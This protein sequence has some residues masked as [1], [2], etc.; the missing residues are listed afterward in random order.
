M[1]KNYNTN[2]KQTHSGN[3]GSVFSKCRGFAHSLLFLIIATLC[4]ILGVAEVNAQASITFPP[5]PNTS[6]NATN[7]TI[8][9]SQALTGFTVYTSLPGKATPSLSITNAKDLSDA[10]IPD[11]RYNISTPTGV[12]GFTDKAPYIYQSTFTANVPGVYTIY[13]SAY[14]GTSATGTKKITVLNNTD[15]SFT[16]GDQALKLGDVRGKD[17]SVLAPA[18][19]NSTGQKTYSV[20][21][22][23]NRSVTLTNNCLPEDLPAGT[24]TITVTVPST[25]THI[26]ASKTCKIIVVSS[27]YMQVEDATV[28]IAKGEAYKVFNVASLVRD[29]YGK[30][31]ADYDQGRRE[32]E[33]TIQCI[34]RP[35]G[36]GSLTITGWDSRGEANVT[37]VKPGVYKFE[38]T[39]D[40][41][42]ELGIEYSGVVTITVYK[43]YDNIFSHP[44]AAEVKRVDRLELH[45][46]LG[47]STGNVDLDAE[48]KNTV[49]VE[50]ELLDDNYNEAVAKLY[51]GPTR[52]NGLYIENYDHY[53]FASK[54]LGTYR[55]RVSVETPDAYS[56][57]YV[58]FDPYT[59]DFTVNVTGDFVVHDGAN[60]A[61]G[62]EYDLD[63]YMP[64]SKKVIVAAGGITYTCSSSVP[65][66]TGNKF[67]CSQLGTYTITAHVPATAYNTERNVSFKITVKPAH[68]HDEVITETYR[69]LKW[70]KN[71]VPAWD[72]T[73]HLNGSV[74][75][76]D[77][78][79][80]ID[81]DEAGNDL[82]TVTLVT[83][84]PIYAALENHIDFEGECYWGGDAYHYPLLYF[85]GVKQAYEIEGDI[86]IPETVSFNGIEYK[87]T[88]IG[89]SAF[90][91]RDNFVH[92]NVYTKSADCWGVNAKLLHVTFPNNLEKIDQYAFS[93][94]FNSQVPSGLTF[95]EGSKL[96]RIERAAF[97]YNYIS[98][99]LDF[100]NCKELESI[101][102]YAFSQYTWGFD[103]DHPASFKKADFSGC[104]KLS[105]F[106]AYAFIRNRNLKTLDV[107]NIALDATYAAGFGQYSF[108]DCSISELIFDNAFIGYFYQSCFEGNKLNGQT[109][110]FTKLKN[111]Y[112]LD[113]YPWSFRDT[114]VLNL[115]IPTTSTTFWQ[116][117]FDQSDAGVPALA[118]V[119]FTSTNA[120]ATVQMKKRV[121]I[122]LVF[123]DHGSANTSINIYA[124]LALIG[125]SQYGLLGLE[126]GDQKDVVD[127]FSDVNG[128]RVFPFLTSNTS[129]VRTMSYFRPLDYKNI[130]VFDNSHMYDAN[131]SESESHELGDF[132]RTPENI[133]Y[134]NIEMLT[135]YTATGYNVAAKQVTMTALG[136]AS[137][138]P[139][140]GGIY[141]KRKGTS[142]DRED[143]EILYMLT[144]P[145]YSSCGTYSGI[146][147]LKGGGKDAVDL[148]DAPH[149]TETSTQFISKGGTFYYCTG[150][151]LGAFKAYLDLP[152]KILT[153]ADQG[154]GSSNAK[155][156]SLSFIWEDAPADDATSV[157]AI[158]DFN[159]SSGDYYNMQGMKVKVPQA[160]VIYIHNGRKVIMK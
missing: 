80:S 25:S 137:G 9:L 107:S 39:K 76:A 123:G 45:D 49:N 26:N 128:P 75:G 57:E 33:W 21:N 50:Y 53:I 130:K 16:K 97:A 132:F 87:V 120:D 61:L 104:T 34:E 38:F 156:S 96:R 148:S 20:R 41:S 66:I 139:T 133:A 157:E 55:V 124:P 31:P 111:H 47:V 135:P 52:I 8:S 63:D 42:Y 89:N 29:V 7:Q 15:I 44:D 13:A 22:S 160:G 64:L 88:S 85:N 79:Y 99:D 4:S 59:H 113:F 92:L 27:E 74:A 126:G 106:G 119:F 65:V 6:I 32:Y 94:N 54:K 1:N 60:V 43:E 100:T 86:E 12:S 150:G 10:T 134:N 101:A 5:S 3:E 122:G 125:R 37:F 83:S 69:G 23:S 30:T 71:Y 116:Q 108:S 62:K 19:S 18:T 117:A 147:Y 70:N 118:N 51:N 95:K 158:T 72:F 73:Q 67:T 149:M 145:E 40:D 110:D 11:Y 159:A 90:L 36:V 68:I 81:Y 151:T 138:I 93:E 14:F 146:N 143:N 46:L 129:G 24:Y 77:V 136:A 105:T 28:T 140:K 152:E 153:A 142:T 98:E 141:Y 112:Y 102:D 56:G 131:K 103:P 17:I 127:E 35:E 114:G 91:R 155:V 121:G 48:I 58:T 2:G 109:L 115:I 78:R 84:M 82:G 144:D 154:F